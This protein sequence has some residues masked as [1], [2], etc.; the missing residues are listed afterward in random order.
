M[1]RPFASLS[2]SHSVSFWRASELASS[3]QNGCKMAPN[4]ANSLWPASQPA[5]ASRSALSARNCCINQHEPKR[6]PNERRQQSLLGHTCQSIGCHRAFEFPPPNEA[7]ALLSKWSLSHLG[8]TVFA[9]MANC[10]LWTGN[11][12]G[13]M[14]RLWSARESRGPSKSPADELGLFLGFVFLAN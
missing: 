8:C 9:Q 4:L 5:K 7:L 6:E 1:G 10:G 14:E 2:G 11:G 13:K 3:R 12:R